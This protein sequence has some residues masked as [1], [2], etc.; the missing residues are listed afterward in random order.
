MSVDCTDCK[1]VE[2]YPYEKEWSKRWFSPKFHGPG[3]RYEI[4]VS[5]LR[6]DIVWVNGPFP[7]GQ[8][9]DLKIFME[10]GMKDHLEENERVEADDGYGD[11][12]PEFTK[13][14]SGIFHA[15]MA[16]G[17]RNDVRARHETANKRIKQ[18]GALSGVFRHDL[19]KH[20]TVFHA[21]ALV[22][23]IAIESGESLFE[24]EG[25]DDNIFYE[26]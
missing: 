20:S 17:V 24:I 18:F 23:Q 5:I 10:F 2:P 4:G 8:Y 7:C 11:A 1:I 14:K 3:L 19:S 25:Y 15:P 9:N 13:T 22:T 21:V 26:E 6:G 12:N 16:A